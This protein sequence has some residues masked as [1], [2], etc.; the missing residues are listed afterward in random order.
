[1]PNG[2][3]PRIGGVVSPART[4]RRISVFDTTLRD[5]EQAPGNAMTPEQKLE[6]ALRI[7]ELGADRI[8][9]GFPAASPRDFE[10]TQLISKGLKDAQF[11]TFC[12]AVRGDVE[13]AVEAG[14][15]ANHQVET[16]TVGSDVHLRYKR[17]ISRREAIEEIVDVV[18]FAKSFGVEEV[19]VAIEDATRG[20]EEHL[21]ATTEAVLEAGASCI[22]VPDTVGAMVPGEYGELI[23]KFREWAPTA[24]I[25]THCHD[26]F[27][28][29]LANALAGM[30]AGADEVQVTLGGIGER[31]GN[32]SLEQFAATLAYKSD[33]YGAYSTVDIA[34]MHEAYTALRRIIKMEEP[35][36][37]PIVGAYAFGSA[38]G[39]HQQGLLRN[40][41]TYEYVEPARFGRKTEILIGRHSGRAVLR[42]LLDELGI[43]ADDAQV[44]ELYRAHVSER[45]GSDCEDLS[46]VRDRLDRELASWPRK[47][48]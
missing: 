27:G 35:R 38:A 42:H 43:V 6:M 46:V 31:A 14:G 24:R 3:T 30:E 28:L 48:R 9:A 21:R 5:G 17:G 36:N 8:E 26:D 44:E 1:M 23:A 45:P 19:A 40:P 12:R 13:A 34:G 7:E 2:W 4:A 16:V 37:K 41:E 10:A 18:E 25:S 29:S 15:T 20:A 22:V 11:V 32:T 39:I 33:F 47:G